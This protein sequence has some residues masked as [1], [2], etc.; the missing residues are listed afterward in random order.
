ML[1]SVGIVVTIIG[2][3]MSVVNAGK[4]MHT[5]Q[6]IQAWYYYKSQLEAYRTSLCIGLVI[7]VIGVVILLALHI[8][9]QN[10]N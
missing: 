8:K 5:S 10:K 7:T 1:K 4:F 9:S 6:E 3:I 2:A